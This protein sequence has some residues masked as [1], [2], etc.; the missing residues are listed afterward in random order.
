MKCG[1]SSLYNY[2]IQHPEICSC[3][4]KEP[5]FFSENQS[6]R[7]NGV[8][9]YEDLW[10][11]DS[12]I[13]RLALEASTGYTKYP[14]ELDVPRKIR[15]YGLRP[16]FIYVVRNPF[17]RIRSHYE[18]M[19]AIPGF[20][21]TLPFSADTFV[22]TSK[23]FLQLEQYRLYFPREKFLVIDF[24]D[25]RT[26]PRASVSKVCRFLGLS[27][28]HI[29]DSYPV[30]H[31]TPS[32]TDAFLSRNAFLGKTA[33]LLPKKVRRLGRQV[34]EGTFRRAEWTKEQRE[35]VFQQLAQ[36][37][38]R[39]QSE[40]GFD[41]SKWGWSTAQTGLAISSE[42]QLAQGARK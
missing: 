11:F 8:T 9:K 27:D 39:F 12:R 1:T 15:A 35:I 26:S 37:M 24:D 38:L 3:I 36:D 4:K 28:E 18:H 20:D 10:N 2:L 21:R 17:D 22:N 6:H 25:L 23:Y 42:G 40:Y 31:R 30:H 19:T 5:E 16:K 34:L 14:E 13:H 41:V 32:P 33:G 7:Y 29:P